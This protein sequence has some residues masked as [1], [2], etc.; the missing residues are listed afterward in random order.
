[1]IGIRILLS[2]TSDMTNY[3]FNLYDNGE[4]VLM[5]ANAPDFNYLVDENYS[6]VHRLELDYFHVDN[7]DLFSDKILVVE[8]NFTRPVLEALVVSY[9]IF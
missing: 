7:E 8:R 9:E 5:A 6:G 2:S 4:P 3:R 1:M